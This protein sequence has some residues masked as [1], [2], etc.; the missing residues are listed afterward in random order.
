MK[1]HWAWSII[2]IWGLAVATSA[3]ADAVIDDFQ[4][5]QSIVGGPGGGAFGPVSTTVGGAGIL[6]GSRT[7]NL[8]GN[9][10]AG[11]TVELKSG[12]GFLFYGTGPTS[13]G[14]GN[15]LYNGGGA[16]LGGLLAMT[17][18]IDVTLV[19][20][21]HGSAQTTI[22]ITIKDGSISRTVSVALNASTL[23]PQT[24]TFDFTGLGLDFNNI[25][26]LLLSLDSTTSN[27]ADVLLQNLIARMTPVPEPTSVATWTVLSL[28]GVWYV[29]RVRRGRSAA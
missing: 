26:S 24:L 14:L 5:F 25:V 21:N 17:Q 15:L 23:A 27:G 28:G 8:S 22:S 29:R 1:S 12:L 2:A 18:A 7:M 19:S 4:T 3:R 20:L 6:G 9:A 11:Q 16:G 13:N 10:T